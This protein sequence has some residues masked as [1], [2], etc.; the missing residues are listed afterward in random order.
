MSFQSFSRDEI[1]ELT[2]AWRLLTAL[3]ALSVIVGVIVLVKPSHSLATLAVITGV[4]VLIDSIAELAIALF[5]ERSGIAAV[6]GVLGI[7][8]GI[9]LI[10]HPTK[11]VTAIAI[12]IGIWLVALGVIRLVTALSL[13]R[14]AWSI[15]AGI[16]EIIAG[17]AIVSSPHIGYATL[18]LLV[19]IAFILNGIAF[20]TL[21]WAMHGL[22][23]SDDSG[24]A[25]DEPADVAAPMA[26]S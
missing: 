5:G 16:V 14:G 13:R 8:V 19:G 26:N 21:G 17:I 10:R 6:L 25:S 22:R 11:A 3:G 1:R 9:L 18:A 20:L 23:S 7:V 4:F 15:V 24:L 2:W 12:L